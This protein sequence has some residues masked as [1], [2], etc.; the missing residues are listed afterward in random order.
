ME[1]QAENA[2]SSFFYYMW[3]AWS[4]EECKAVYGGMYPHFWENGTRWP[5]SPSTGRLSGSTWSF[6]K[7][8]AGYWWNV[9]SPSM[10]DDA[11]GTG[12]QTLKI[13]K[14]ADKHH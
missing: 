4:M 6:R 2:V 7:T 13:K 8:T 3:N 11:S 1:Y 5:T 9:L 12:V 10:T 14:Y